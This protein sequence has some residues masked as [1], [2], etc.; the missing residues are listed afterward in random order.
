MSSGDLAL[1]GVTRHQAGNYTCLASN[2]EGDGESNIAQLKVMCKY[3][4]N[5]I[6]C[7]NKPFCNKNNKIK[8]KEIISFNIIHNHVIT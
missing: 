7:I 6:Y 2:V 3:I 4:A 5:N 8:M 1:Q